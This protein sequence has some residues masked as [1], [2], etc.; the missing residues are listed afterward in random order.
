MGELE[1]PR[2]EVKILRA[3]KEHACVEGHSGTCGNGVE[4]R[5]IV[6]PAD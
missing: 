5:G 6:L 2:A 1:K 4:R 3:E